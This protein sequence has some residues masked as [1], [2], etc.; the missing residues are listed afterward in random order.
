ME[1]KLYLNGKKTTKNEVKEMIG[2][3]KLKKMI[4]KSK[5]AFMRNPSEQNSY[6]FAGY[7]KSHNKLDGFYYGMF[8][9][10]FE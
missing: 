8:T 5:E 3:E 6:F 1:T 2:E 9:I 4:K 7:S 10:K